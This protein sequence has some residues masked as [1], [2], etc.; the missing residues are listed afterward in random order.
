MVKQVIRFMVRQV[1]SRSG[2]DR[3]RGPPR[4]Q[5]R[6]KTPLFFGTTRIAVVHY[7]SLST[8]VLVRGLPREGLAFFR[9]RRSENGE[10]TSEEVH[11][12]VDSGIPLHVHN[13]R[14]IYQTR[15]CEMIRLSYERVCVLASGTPF[16]LTLIGLLHAMAA[17][18]A[19]HG[20]R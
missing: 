11:L 6:G 15:W 14:G 2:S 16:Q 8:I 3:Q 1:Q 19:S 13:T 20:C 18:P 4:I 7:I 9:L 12:S 17:D 10:Y 5:P